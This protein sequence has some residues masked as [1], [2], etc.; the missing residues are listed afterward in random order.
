[1]RYEFSEEGIIYKGVR[2]N[3]NNGRTANNGQKIWTKKQQKHKCLK[4]I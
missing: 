1:M 3:V 2:V 4:I